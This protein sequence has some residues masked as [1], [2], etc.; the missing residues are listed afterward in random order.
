M[1][2]GVE[3]VGCGVG[4]CGGG[5]GSGRWA[6]GW[7]GWRVGGWGGILPP[8]VEHRRYRRRAALP[9]PV[10]RMRA[11]EREIT[12]AMIHLSFR[13]R[14]LFDPRRR[15]YGDKSASKITAPKGS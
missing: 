1:G 6:V 11:R 14:R 8:A 10:A 4:G 2:A 13:C 9:G 7:G 5:D 3:T 12:H 15:F